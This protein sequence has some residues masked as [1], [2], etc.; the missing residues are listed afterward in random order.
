M[1]G[2]QI[3]EVGSCP[4]D[5][6][7]NTRKRCLNEKS[8]CDSTSLAHKQIKL[9]STGEAS[10]PV[11]PSSGNDGTPVGSILTP[12]ENEENKEEGEESRVKCLSYGLISVIGR[13]RVMEDAVTVA[14]DRKINGYDLFAVYDGHCGSYAAKAYRYRLHLLIAEAVDARTASIGGGI[15]EEAEYWKKVMGASF[16]KM[17]KEVRDGQVEGGTAGST[18]LVVLVGKEKLVAA[19]CGNSRAVLCR[20]GVAA[21]ISR[22][23]KVASSSHANGSAVFI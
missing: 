13:R 23:H 1:D 16:N 9:N 8:P 22:D 12:G 14:V 17:D 7:A 20:D 11:L 4:V 15:S 2:L 3:P 5:G 6:C 18:A 10:W 21:P 19:N